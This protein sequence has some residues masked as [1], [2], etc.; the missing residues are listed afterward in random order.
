MIEAVN[1]RE[2]AKIREECA[3]QESK[4]AAFRGQVEAFVRD[5]ES[6]KRGRREA[7]LQ[8]KIRHRQKDERDFTEFLDRLEQ[9]KA[10]KRVQSKKNP[11]FGKK[12]EC[13]DCRTLTQSN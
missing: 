7:A 10:E 13:Q 1:S 2:A 8:D 12:Q 4:A 11:F 3:Q 9:E 6:V 5:D